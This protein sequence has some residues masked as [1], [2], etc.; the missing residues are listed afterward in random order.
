[1]AFVWGSTAIAQTRPTSHP[2]TLATTTTRPAYRAT[3][4]PGFVRVAVGDRI[5]FCEPADQAWVKATF[6]TIPPTTHPTTT[7]TDMSQKLAKIR[8]IFKAQLVADLALPKPELVDELIDGTILPSLKR[9][10]AVKSPVIYLV[11]S[12][13]KLKDVMKAGWVNPRYYLN[14]VADEVQ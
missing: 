9:I 2:T 5:A 13:Q 8:S 10:E 14:R 12:K 7:A 1:C 3:L 4:P 11:C 6:V